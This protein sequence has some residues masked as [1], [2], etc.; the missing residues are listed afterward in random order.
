LTIVTLLVS[1]LIDLAY[2]SHLRGSVSYYVMQTPLWVPQ[3]LL[4]LSAILLWLAL[5]ARA[6]RLLLGEQ[7]ERPADASAPVHQGHAS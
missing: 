1:G 5:A 4:A 3:A 6:I 2:R 7:P